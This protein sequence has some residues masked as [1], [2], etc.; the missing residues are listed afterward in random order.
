[1]DYAIIYMKFVREMLSND[2]EPLEENFYESVIES[3]RREGASG[4]I[5]R[6]VLAT[7]KSLFLI[8]LMKELK[9]VYTGT[10]KR[11]DIHS[12]PRPEREV[13]ERVFSII[14]AFEKRPHSFQEPV[15]LD[16]TKPDISAEVK[17]ENA[18]EEK[19][20]VF[21]LKPYPKIIDRGLNLGPFNKGDV[22]YL[23]RRLATDLANSG[24]VE[25]IP[26][27]YQREE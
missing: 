21:F 13:L 1:M 8:R 2:L 18:Q 6:S 20:L 3:T 14:E 17:P 26:K 24:Y 9:L 22:A 25:E 10:L 11:E 23:P 4:T 19:T 7:L 16:L 27:K 12:L 5:T 15:S